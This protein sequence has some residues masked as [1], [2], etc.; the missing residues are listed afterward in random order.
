MLGVIYSEVAGRVMEKDVRKRVRRDEDDNSW[1]DVH[2]VIRRDLWEKCKELGFNRSKLINDLLEEFIT[3]F[4]TF[5]R[6]KHV[7]PPRFEL[8][9]P[10]PKAGRITRLPYGPLLECLKSLKKTI[11]KNFNN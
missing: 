8:G 3:L 5:R 1:V 2:I 11:A 10:A 7:G 6:Y 9:S 4:E